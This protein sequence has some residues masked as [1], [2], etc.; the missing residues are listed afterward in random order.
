MIRWSCDL[1]RHP[2]NRWSYPKNIFGKKGKRS[3]LFFWMIL[4]VWAGLGN[5]LACVVRCKCWWCGGGRPTKQQKTMKNSEQ[6][7]NNVFK[8]LW[9]TW[10]IGE[11]STKNQPNIDEKRDNSCKIHPKSVT[12]VVKVTQMEPSSYHVRI[13]NILFQEKWEN[14]ANGAESRL[15]TPF[16]ES[17]SAWPGKQRTE[18]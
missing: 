16:V 1:A 10:T 3:P 2:M 5:H 15:R 11:T 12:R 17:G 9:K 13:F 18:K 4:E 7:M 8:N 6:L 14:G